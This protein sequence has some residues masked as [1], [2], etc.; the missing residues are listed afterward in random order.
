MAIV[1]IYKIK[2][3]FLFFIKIKTKEVCITSLDKNVFSSSFEIT[4]STV[5]Y[6]S[7]ITKRLGS[8]LRSFDWRRFYHMQSVSLEKFQVPVATHVHPSKHFWVYCVTYPLKKRGWDKSKWFPSAYEREIYTIK[9]LN[10]I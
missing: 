7:Q 1:S 10:F 4:I 8:K 2:D 6:I 9:I 3:I 5:N